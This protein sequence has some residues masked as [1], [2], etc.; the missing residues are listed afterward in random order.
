MI[1]S[2]ES[3]IVQIDCGSTLLAELTPGACHNMGLQEGDVVYCLFK[4]HSIGYLSEIDSQPYQRVVSHGDGSYFL[5]T[6]ISV[7]KSFL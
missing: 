1:Q 5:G 2:G 4:A 6:N 3:V 7:A